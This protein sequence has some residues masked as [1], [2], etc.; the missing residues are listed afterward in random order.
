[1]T[2]PWSQARAAAAKSPWR[3]AL[4]A[5]LSLRGAWAGPGYEVRAGMIHVGA[6]DD[7]ASWTFPAQAVVIDSVA[8]R[9]RLRRVRM[10]IDAVR[11][12]DRFER[13]IGEAA[14]YERL[15]SELAKEKRSAPLNIRRRQATVAG[16]ALTRIRDDPR[17]GARAGDPVLWYYFHGGAGEA[18]SDPETAAHAFDGDPVT[19]WEP[20]STVPAEEYERLPREDKGEVYYLV[21]GT[22]GRQSRTSRAEYE[23]TPADARRAQY[24]SRSLDRWYV[25]LDLGRV[26]PVRRVVLRFARE[27]EGEPFRQVRLLASRSSD[28][29]EP[30]SLL[31]RTTS[32]NVDHRV[33]AFDLDLEG[34][35]QYVQIQRLRIAV[36]DS[37]LERFE[38]VSA[39]QFAALPADD[40]GAIDYYVWD[41]LGGER[42]TDAESYARVEPDRRG[43]RQFYRR[44]RPRL[45][46]V[47]VWAQGDNVALGI[48]EGGGS[49]DL[50]GSFTVERG[51]DGLYDTYFTQGLWR[52][53]EHEDP[54]RWVL[55]V[56]LGAAYW[57]NYLRL[58]KRCCPRE[59]VVVVE[60]ADGGTDPQG[61]LTWR[62]L[63]RSAG[64]GDANSPEDYVIQQEVGGQQPTRYLRSYI[65]Q[66][67]HSPTFD[68]RELQLFADGYAAEAVLTSP[69][70]E[71]PEAAVL[72]RIG[73]EAERPVPGV[74]D[75]E[76]RTR[77]GD[78]AQEVTGYF[79]S[80]GFPRTR[81]EYEALPASFRGPAVT[82]RVPADGWSP[83]SQRYRQP[84]DRVTSP[85]PRRYLQL[86]VRLRTA[87][88]GAT[89]AIG[90]IELSLRPP[91]ARDAVA[92]IWPDSVEAGRSETFDVY[93]QARFVEQD[94]EGGLSTGFDEIRLD[95]HSMEHLE[96]V[97]VAVGGDRMW[98][99][100]DAQPGV[101]TGNG[102]GDWARVVEAT[103]TGEPGTLRLRLS[104]KV[105][106]AADGVRAYY[107]TVV[108]AG[109]E[110]P[111]D[112]DGRLL[113]EVTYLNLP[114]AERGRELYLVRDSGGPAADARLDSV[115]RM[116]YFDRPAEARAGVRYFRKVSDGEYPFDRAGSPLTRESFLALPPQEQG[117]VVAEGETIRLRLRGTVVRYGTTVEVWVRDADQ[118]VWQQVDPGDA[119]AAAPGTSLTVKVPLQRRVLRRLEIAPAVVTPNGDGVNDAAQI[120]FAVGNAV[121]T[122]PVRVEVFDLS[123]RRVWL[124]EGNEDGLAQVLW[125]GR[126]GAGRLV[127]P[128]LYVVRVAVQVDA[129]GERETS[130]TRSI[131]VAY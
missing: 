102:P 73:W 60:A 116:A 20:R 130:A 6:P 122:R 55:T 8:Q 23:A 100:D 93:I 69:L 39:E 30:F 5:A 37:R 94:P 111:V 29:H 57:L 131:G 3:V 85:S 14:D 16:V 18:G 104:R 58:L 46:E 123:G 36:T 84:G 88:A 70:I 12:A 105:G 15:L 76:L 63:V 74:T 129:E 77:T 35:G 28:R 49:A 118:E 26:V 67:R 1:M 38:K 117:A 78:R 81:E 65:Q 59:E 33:L 61:Q 125:D 2:A 34:R 54:N 90:A 75:V 50:P 72:D 97:E 25:D 47:E 113:Q 108:R 42:Q 128:G 41:A 7:W 19:C 11:D 106:P 86:E 101:L 64:H 44:E 115:D 66:D 120:R 95:P 121:I 71:L 103:A 96:L 48:L 62:E 9:V 124:L 109:D 82:H 24:H 68:T 51:F 13:R 89:P 91:A 22:D 31:A 107:R 119:T 56:D 80:A 114:E 126:D 52:P 27:G 92:E 17:S 127:R 87:D 40:Q 32:P 43:R 83:W 79:T 99:A 98:P 21:S 10:D 53:E 110:V 45:A 4:L 112:E